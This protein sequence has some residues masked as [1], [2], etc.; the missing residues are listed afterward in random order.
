MYVGSA[1]GTDGIWSRW[2]S[3]IYTGHAGN[4]KLDNLVKEMGIEHVQKYFKFSL[5]ESYRPSTND[6]YILSREGYWKSVLLTR[7]YGYNAN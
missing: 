1:T 5:L 7:E 6:D 2:G 3:Y 4:K